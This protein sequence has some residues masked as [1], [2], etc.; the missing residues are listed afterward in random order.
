MQNTSVENIDF[1]AVHHLRTL[2][3]IISEIAPFKPN[4]LKLSHQLGISRETLLRYLYL[5]E[6]A[7]LVS[8]LQSET[9]GISKMNKPV[10]VY[11]NNTNLSF[12]LPYDKANTGSIRETFFNNQLKVRHKVLYS[13]AEDFSVDDLY[14]FE[15]GGKNKKHRQIK[16]VENAFI[17]ADNIEH[18]LHYS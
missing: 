3:S 5:L 13:P 10:K 16:G 9:K 4:I 18:S 12:A 14:T 11:L 15:I 1:N 2:I 6:S 8:L 17:A 7:D